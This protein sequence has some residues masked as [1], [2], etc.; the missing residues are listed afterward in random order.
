MKDK[1][2]VSRYKSQVP[3]GSIVRHFKWETEEDHT[4]RRY[5]YQ[6]IGYAEHTETNEDMVIYQALYPPFT[7]YARPFEMFISRVDKNK[8]PDIKQTFRFEKSNTDGVLM[9]MY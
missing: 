4:G 9:L 7:V 8:Y 3:I 6:I 1:M 5:L 2:T